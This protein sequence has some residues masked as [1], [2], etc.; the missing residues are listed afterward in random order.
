MA[1]DD[2]TLRVAPVLGDVFVGPADGLGDIAD[3]GVHVHGRQEPV[4]GGHED[5]SLV[6]EHLRLDLNVLL[7]PGLPAAA[8]NPEDDRE[9]FR[10]SRG[11]DIE[12][13]PLVSLLDV[14]DVALD[15]LCPYF[16]GDGKDDEKRE[17]ESHDLC[18][19]RGGLPE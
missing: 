17:G 15:I 13:L 1:H 3:N 7:V 14:G 6:G 18:L 19:S 8:V 5:E 16:G 9:V 2:D 11:V 4:V 10:I 12:Y